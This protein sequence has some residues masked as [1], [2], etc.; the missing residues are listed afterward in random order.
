[1][2]FELNFVA[3]VLNPTY[4]FMRVERSE[5]CSMVLQNEHQLTFNACKR[6][7]VL[8]HVP[9]NEVITSYEVLEAK[10][11]ELGWE[12]YQDGGSDDGARPELLQFHKP[13]SVH[14]IPLPSD[15]SELRSV[16]MYDIVVKSH[17][18]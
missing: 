6:R 14:L 1:M 7:R 16:H 18:R 15:F 17:P 11:A 9:T 3:P 8:V 5:E 10:L 13:S 2:W 12:R 4:E